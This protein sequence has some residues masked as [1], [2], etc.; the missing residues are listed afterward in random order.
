[1][2][3]PLTCAL[4]SARSQQRAYGVEMTGPQQGYD[5][6]YAAGGSGGDGGGAYDD[7]A[8]E[9]ASGGD[10]YADETQIAMDSGR[11][12]SQPAS[13]TAL[14][15]RG[16]V[17]RGQLPPAQ[18]VEDLQAQIRMLQDQ[19]ASQAQPP[20][21]Q[22][23]APL[24]PLQSPM[25]GPQQQPLYSAVADRRV[26]TNRSPAPLQRAGTATSLR[27]QED[28]RSF[29]GDALERSRS[30]VQGYPQQQPQQPQQQQQ[31]R[32]DEDARSIKGDGADRRPSLVSP[33]AGPAASPRMT[34][35]QFA[36]P[37]A[38]PRSSP[39]PAQPFP[40]QQQQRYTVNADDRC[41]RTHT[42]PPPPPVEL[43]ATAAAAPSS[44]SSFTPPRSHRFYPHSLRRALSFCSVRD[45]A[46]S[47]H[48]VCGAE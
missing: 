8:G 36:A 29:K 27:Q 2:L 17:A 24:S 22:Q 46:G 25:Q 34:A 30:L 15:A 35:Q 6:E 18:T 11:P 16:T 13:P 20:L 45:R 38:S 9:P 23:Q 26:T 33:R 5:E 37:R 41:A 12:S 32:A 7:G 4:T 1:L 43:A 42:S 28:A 3:A 39:Q 48:G 44:P 47:H 21:L 19:L 14:R 40:R 10:D 31:R